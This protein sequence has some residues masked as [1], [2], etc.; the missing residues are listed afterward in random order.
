MS[1]KGFYTFGKALEGG[2]EAAANGNTGMQDATKMYLEKGR[3]NSD[4]RHNFVMSTIWDLK[5]YNGSAEVLRTILN[6]WGV[7]A[8]V[9]ARSG[10]PFTVTSGKDNNLDG[11]N[12]DRADLTGDPR[13]SPN[14]SRADV[15]AAWFNTTVFKPNAAGQPGTA[16]RNILDKP[17]LKTV[18]LG[19]MRTFKLGERL[20]MQFRA[21]ATNAFNMVN[22]KGP[23][24]TLGSSAFGTINEAEAMREL[25]LG[26]RFAF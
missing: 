3:T 22:L 1:F 20:E 15:T 17:G 2:N 7:S 16:G 4:R 5:Y 13:L 8:I 24:T 25:Q 11:N 12:N 18:D 14:R 21:E 23:N 10:A 26:M 9:K 19:L 6:G